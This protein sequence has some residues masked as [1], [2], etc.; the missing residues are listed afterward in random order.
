MLVIQVV[1]LDR[2]GLT[3]ALMKANAAALFAGGR[4]IA[5]AIHAYVV[6]LSEKMNTVKISSEH[7]LKEGGGAYPSKIA[8][9]IG[10]R[11]SPLPCRLPYQQ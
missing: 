7:A 11:K 6:P 10:V 3:M 9:S 4:G 2:N 8:R 1:V 5:L